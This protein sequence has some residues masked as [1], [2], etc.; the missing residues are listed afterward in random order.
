MTFTL[1]GWFVVQAGLNR[2]PSRAH[3]FGGAFLL[4]LG[5]RWFASPRWERRLGSAR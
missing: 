2:D 5:R 3:G 1:L 4:M